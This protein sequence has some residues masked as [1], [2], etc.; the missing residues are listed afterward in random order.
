MNDGWD[1]LLRAQHGVFT[2]DEAMAHGISASRLRW[3][4]TAGRWQSV[5]PRVY[6]AY[7][8]PLSYDSRLW[9]AVRYAGA[10]SVLCL[11]TAAHAWGL[12]PVPPGTV[13][14]LVR[15]TVRLTAARGVQVHRT[16]QLARREVFQSEGPART[17]V[18]RTVLDLVHASDQPEEVC[19]LVAR[20][21]QKGLTNAPRLAAALAGRRLRHSRL[22]RDCL[23]LADGGAHS[24]LEMRHAHLGRVHGLPAPTRQLRRTHGDRSCYLDAVY[25][26]YGVA[27]ELDGRLVHTDPRQWWDDMDRDNQLQ[28]EGLIVQRFP[29]FLLLS[30][31]CRVARDLARALSA[32]GWPGPLLA[33]SSSSCS[34]S[35]G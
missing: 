18:E 20:S 16:G 31:P 10:G 25:E 21:V 3:Q 11:G 9:A 35:G 34:S 1:A 19:A 15:D 28:A 6:A 32:R 5:H 27:V 24:V 23:E 13:H 4:V 30:D 12:F 26:S 33:C 8:G 7:T 29:G 17:G 14:V 22:V 2:I